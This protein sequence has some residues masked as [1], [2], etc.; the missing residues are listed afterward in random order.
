MPHAY[1]RGADARKAY[2]KSGKKPLPPRAGP[3][4]V[5]FVQGISAAPV[6]S[7]NSIEENL[8]D[9]FEE[10][11]RLRQKGYE[12]ILDIQPDSTIPPPRIPTTSLAD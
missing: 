4:Q 1:L 5:S 10:N 11:H 3:L 7:K 9:I 2:L 12:D 6:L 8:G